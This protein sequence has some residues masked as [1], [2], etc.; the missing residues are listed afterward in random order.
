MRKRLVKILSLAFVAGGIYVIHSAWTVFHKPPQAVLVC[1]LDA[2]L[3][4]H[5]PRA[6]T[7]LLIHASDN[8]IS[9]LA[10]PRDLMMPDGHKLN[11]VYGIYGE[12]KFVNEIERLT[13]QRIGKRMFVRLSV[14]N[15]VDQVFPQGIQI[16]LPYAFRYKDRAGGLDYNLPAGRQTLS[17]Q[18]LVY[19]LRDRKSGG[20][21]GDRV[22]LQRFR[23]VTQA[24]L[25]AIARD[26]LALTRVPSAFLEARNIHA[27]ETDMTAR[28][29][30]SLV[31]RARGGIS[32]RRVATKP[33]RGANGSLFE[34]ANP[35]EIQKLAQ[36]ASQG[37]LPPDNLRTFVLN[38]TDI[39]GAARSVSRSLES[40]YGITAEIGNARYRRDRTIVK[41]CP[42]DDLKVRTF[43]SMI[44]HDLKASLV[45]DDTPCKA[46]F[47]IVEVGSDTV[48][49]VLK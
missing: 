46:P 49:R 8:G 42:G 28:D 23:I 19:V 3:N 40:S 44:A 27:I 13:G 22:R 39:Q 16:D 47:L 26:P 29:V 2:G 36:M 35:S 10:I 5:A 14:G 21:L 7:I 37:A 43:A 17:G 9:C 24:L 18:Q 33:F 6:D 45:T 15:A 32:S 38:G 25:R 34:Q 4:S 31:V 11:A 20:N 41:F 48:S 1:G 12:Q 30:L